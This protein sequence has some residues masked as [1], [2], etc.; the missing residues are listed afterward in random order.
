[1]C[2]WIHQG[3]S[4]T[5]NNTGNHYVVAW[6]VNYPPTC[7]YSSTCITSNTAIGCFCCG[8]FLMPLRQP[9]TSH[10]HTAFFLLR[11]RQEKG[12]GVTPIVVWFWI[13]TRFWRCW[14]VKMANKEIYYQGENDTLLTSSHICSVVCHSAGHKDELSACNRGTFSMQ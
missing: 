6:P 8:L 7:S 12:S 5:H 14:L 1:M 10:G 4:G 9:L 11:L 2:N 3:Q 13:L